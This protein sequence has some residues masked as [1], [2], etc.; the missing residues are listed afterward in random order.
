MVRKEKITETSY[1][2]IAGPYSLANEYGLV[3]SLKIEKL[4]KDIKEQIESFESEVD[5]V[6]QISNSITSIEIDY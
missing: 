1:D 5:T 6:L 4:I 2:A 3:D